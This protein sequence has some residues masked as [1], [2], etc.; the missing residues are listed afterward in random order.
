MLYLREC[1]YIN[2]FE[3]N[4]IITLSEQF[5]IFCRLKIDT[6]VF[7]IILIYFRCRYIISIIDTILYDIKF[8]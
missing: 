2:R 7:I 6:I 4:F 1:I 5:D 3:I 8:V